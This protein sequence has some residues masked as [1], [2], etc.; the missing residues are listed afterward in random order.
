MLPYYPALR[1]KPG[2]FAACGHIARRYQSHIQPRF[3]VPPLSERDPEKHRPLTRA[4]IAHI[5]GDRIGH[6]WPLLTAFLDPQFVAS[7]IGDDGIEELYRIAWGVNERL[8]PVLTLADLHKP[9]YRMLLGKGQIKAGIYLIFENVEADLAALVDGVTALGCQAGQC[10]LFVDFT[11]APLGPDFAPAIAEIFDRLNGAAMWAKIIYQASAYPEKL[12]VG[13]GER[14]LISRAEWSTF[15]AMLTECGVAPDR[16]GYGDF[17]ADC[18]KIVFS[19]GKGGGRAI[20]HLRYTGKTHTLVVRG[21]N[22]GAFTPIM[23]GVCRQIIESKEFA[24]RG[25][26]YADNLIWCNAKGQTETCGGSTA[27]REW[28][29]AHHLVRVVKD[30]GAMAGLS[31]RDDVVSEVSEQGLLL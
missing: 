6:N 2:E 14:A 9:A 27:W 3:V 8:V 18:G 7:D 4:E 31:F 17:G 21:S 23:R 12:P 29:T 24:G 16:L 5:M 11:G 1:A 19:K 25:F 15:H 28:N 10:N 22:E 13:P 20:P 30:L 26:S